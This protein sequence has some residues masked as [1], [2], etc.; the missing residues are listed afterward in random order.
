MVGF[1][2]DIRRR[3]SCRSACGIAWHHKWS[4][5]IVEVPLMTPMKWYFHV[6][7]DF[8]AMLRR[9]SYGSASR[10]VIPVA[11]ISSF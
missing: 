5:N 4:G 10:K 2:S 8:S 6:C 7:M 9:R 1:K 3:S 11:K